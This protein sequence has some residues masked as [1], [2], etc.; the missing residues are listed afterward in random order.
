MEQKKVKI[1]TPIKERILQF[2]DYKE[3]NKEIFFKKIDTASTNFR[4]KGAKSDLGS[5]KIV[6]ILTEF[7]EINMEW[8]LT[9]KGEMLKNEM[10]A[11]PAPPETIPENAFYKKILKEKDNEIKELNREVGGL[12]QKNADLQAENA[13]LKNDLAQSKNT[14][15][16]LRNPVRNMPV[17][18]DSLSSELPLAQVPIKES[19]ND[20]LA[21]EKTKF[22]NKYNDYEKE[23]TN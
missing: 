2:V 3:L 6:K 11:S 9:G 7:P 13:I 20:Y 21:K 10:P 14:I 22:I 19:T 18:Q 4:G 17:V 5:D 16:E 1:L 12:Q 15:A 23:T 8:L